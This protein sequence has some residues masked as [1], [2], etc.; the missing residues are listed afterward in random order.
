MYERRLL[1]PGILILLALTFTACNRDERIT[2]KEFVKR[3]VLIDVLVDIHLADGV[4]QDRKFSRKY[5]A[6]SIDLLTPI[7]EKY[8]VNRKMFDTTMYEYTRNPKL[9]DEVYNDVLI[10]LNV[11]LDENSKEDPANTPE[12]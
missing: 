7:L 12:P 10:K 6:D 11:M 3:E 4:T 9:L 5:E 1:Y 2:G 8:Q